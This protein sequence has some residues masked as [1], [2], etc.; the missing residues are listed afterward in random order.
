MVGPE[1]TVIYLFTN[2]EF[3]HT[4]I[5]FGAHFSDGPSWWNFA[6]TSPRSNQSKNEGR[7]WWCDKQLPSALNCCIARDGCSMNY[8]SWEGLSQGRMIHSE[9]AW[10]SNAAIRKH[11]DN[12]W[13]LPSMWS[14][15]NESILMIDAGRSLEVF[16][17]TELCERWRRLM[18]G[19]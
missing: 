6:F 19:K 1:L 4:A 5:E 7:T 9:S 18:I 16:V 2:N 15:K 12:S 13:T 14:S 10:S 11:K 8:A 17:Y 3:K